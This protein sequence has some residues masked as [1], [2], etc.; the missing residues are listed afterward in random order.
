[1]PRKKST[2]DFLLIILTFSLLAIGLIMVYSASAIWAEYKFH[3][4]FFFAKRQLLFASAGVIAM[5]FIMNIDYWTWRDWSKVLII[6]C[7][8]LLVLVLIPGVGMVRNGSRSWIGVGAFSIQPSEF[9]KLAMIAFLAKYLSENQKNI[10]SFKRG[11]LPALALVFFAFGMIMLQPDLGTGTVMVGTCIA[12]IFV[13][14]ARIS[15]FIGLGILGLAGFA[16]LVLSAPYRIKRITSFLNPWEDPL[17]SGFQIIQSLYAIGPGGLFGLGLGQSRQKFFYLPEPQT[18]FIFAILAEELGFI[19]GS[20]VLLLFSLLLWRGVRIALG[21][22][23]L[24]GS[25]LAIGIISMVAIQ[26]MINI[27]V[28]TGLMPVTG[29]TLPFLSYGGS[30]LT[31]MLMAIGVLLNISKHAK[32]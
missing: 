5:F 32:Y 12:M 13:A 9:M 22:P 6:V 29:I 11:L 26:V 21:A 27:G 16:A 23:D 15:H 8:L 20:L 7:F 4:S 30:S 31:L 24:Y 17:G 25:F 2:P 10:T 3:D 18:D 14:G 28:V 1:M 19:G